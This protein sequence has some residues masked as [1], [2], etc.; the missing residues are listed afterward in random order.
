MTTPLAVVLRTSV[1]AL[2]LA[3]SADAAQTVTQSFTLQPGWNAI[4]LEVA[5]PDGDPEVVFQGLPIR[6][7]WT[8]RTRLTSLEFVADASEEQLRDTGWLGY[9][10]P[11]RPD[12]FL[13]NLQTIQVNRPYLIKLGGTSPAVLSV[14][15]RPALRRQRWQPDAFNLVGVG[16]TA[17]PPTF[18]SYFAPAPEL[19]GQQIYR[20]EA[21]GAWRQAAPTESMRAGEAFWIFCSGASDYGGPFEVGLPVGDA[22]DFGP[23]G[24]H[25][26]LELANRRTTGVTVSLTF[27]DESGGS[28]VIER[29]SDSIATTAWTPLPTTTS[30]SIPA[31][32]TSRL[33]LG[34]RRSQLTG[35]SYEALIEISDGAVRRWL[36][37][38]V[39]GWGTTTLGGVTAA[40]LGSSPVAGLWIGTVTL[41]QV[42]E[43]HH[44]SDIVTSTDTPAELEARL[45]LH[46]DDSGAVRL[47]QEVLQMWQD[48][49]TTVDPETGNN[50]TLTNGRFVQVINKA[51]LADFRGATI[52]GNAQVG[53]RIS[54]PF[55]DFPVGTFAVAGTGTWGSAVSFALTLAADDPTNPF[56]HRYHPE[57][58]EAA[59][60]YAVGRTIT[61]SFGSPPA[62]PPPDW[63][64]G[65]VAG[66]YS[67]ILTGL[68]NRPIRVS[69]TFTLQ[70]FSSD[71]ELIQ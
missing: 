32:G 24:Q 59:E 62:D 51:R 5:P 41:N 40:K 53:R 19:A 50:V 11:T 15:G 25:I 58:D 9:F 1:A 3:A 49:T 27:V 16:L 36:P 21:G 48:G 43:V 47:L 52:R 55:L 46:V 63:G 69:G 34:A 18:Q 57:H 4:Y 12:A 14:T 44:P 68:H 20:L 22:L 67:E 23:I 39:D 70:R 37:A 2:L 29:E 13:S 10:P 33:F 28:N 61:L 56:R 8:W 66:T 38:R 60:S 6:S 64:T 54:T 17:T 42:N 30:V 31:E 65:E 35:P 26:G 7:V 71:G 45:I